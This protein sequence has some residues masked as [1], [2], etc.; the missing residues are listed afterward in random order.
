MCETAPFWA[1]SRTLEMNVPAILG[2]EDSSSSLPMIALLAEVSAEIQ[3]RVWAE[4]S[5]EVRYSRRPSVDSGSALSSSL[6]RASAPLGPN[7]FEANMDSSLGSVLVVPVPLR[8]V[9]KTSA[10]F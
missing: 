9:S 10:I 2:S 8:Y 6:I 4:T 3:A 7:S 5:R 1:R